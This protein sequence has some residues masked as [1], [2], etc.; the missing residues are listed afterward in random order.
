[1]AEAAPNDEPSEEPR[2]PSCGVALVR[3]GGATLRAGGREVAIEHY[4]CPR[5]GRRRSRRSDEGFRDT[6]VDLTA[7]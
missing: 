3:L 4:V 1:M 7:G 5:C 6:T 2:C